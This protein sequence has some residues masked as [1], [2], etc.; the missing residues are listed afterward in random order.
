MCTVGRQWASLYTRPFFMFIYALSNFLTSTDL[1]KDIFSC[2]AQ[3]RP[4]HPERSVCEVE[5]RTSARQSRA[6]SRARISSF[7]LVDPDATHRPT[8]STAGGVYAFLRS[9]WHE[10]RYITFRKVAGILM[11]T[12]CHKCLYASKKI[13]KLRADQKSVTCWHF[14]KLMV[15]YYRFVDNS[16]SWKSI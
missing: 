13:Y 3:S 9:G 8:G 12:D 7:S 5:L 6:G 11:E 16:T 1:I 14:N 15:Y 10:G 2:K 4:C